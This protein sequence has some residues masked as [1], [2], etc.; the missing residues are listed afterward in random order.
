MRYQHDVCGWI[1]KHIKRNEKGT[2][3]QLT[4]HQR[5]ILRLAFAFDAEGRLAYDTIIFSCPKK[6]GK[7]TIN[8]VISLWWA[9]TQEPP[10]EIKVT[11]NDLEQAVGRVF[12]N[13]AGLIKHNPDL[14]RRAAVQV[15]QI[16]I[17]SSET[18]IDAI[19]SDYKGEAGSDHGLTSWDELWGYSS[20]SSRRLYEELTPVPTRTNSI[21]VISTY[22][23]WENESTLL[24]DLYKQSVGP[25][26]H[27]EGQGTRI[28][29]TLPIYAHPTARLFAYW[30]HTPRMPW[31]TPPL[32]RESTSQSATRHLCPFTRQSL[33]HG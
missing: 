33:D 24:W 15:K 2:P 17:R 4:T 22:A 1:D 26:E 25:E 16:L 9:F 14:A 12:K 6:S 23:G 13:M 32:L 8:A 5:E 19:G 30:D 20:E 11:A 27:P 3:F 31:Q 18:I 28:H 10:N 29:P 21:R 7:T